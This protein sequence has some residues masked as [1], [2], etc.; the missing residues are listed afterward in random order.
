MFEWLKNLFSN[1][2]NSISKIREIADRI[3]RFMDRFQ[4]AKDLENFELA[5]KFYKYILNSDTV[6]EAL[7]Y[8]KEFYRRLKEKG[9]DLDKYERSR[10]YSD[11]NFDDNPIHNSTR[12]NPIHHSTHD[13]HSKSSDDSAIAGFYVA[14]EIIN[15]AQDSNSSDNSDS[16][17]DSSAISGEGG[18]FG[19][20]GSSGSWEDTGTDNS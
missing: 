4:F 20:A 16:F 6:E 18:E 1:E 7:H 19:G 5:D 10:I 8:E 9:L 17:S 15:S 13:N 3:K 2:S 14:N 11:R 12:E